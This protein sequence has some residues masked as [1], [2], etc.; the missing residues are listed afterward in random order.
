[1]KKVIIAGILCTLVLGMRASDYKYLQFTLTDG[2]TQSIAATG[3]N[4][5]FS[6]GTLIATNGENTLSIPVANL[7]KMAFSNEEDITGIKTID[8]ETLPQD[9]D[10]TIFDLQGRQVTKDHMRKGIYIV[11]T[12]D[13]T[14]KITMR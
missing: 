3:A 6:D 11:K 1:M 7:E 12:C 14:F 2:T 5:S 13:K 9:E 4:I 8:I 10:I